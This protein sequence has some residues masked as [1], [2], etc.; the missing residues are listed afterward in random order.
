MDD[1]LLTATTSFST[2]NSDN[3]IVIIAI[4]LVICAVIAGITMFLLNYRSPVGFQYPTNSSCLC[5]I[6]I[7]IGSGDS[8]VRFTTINPPD[9]TFYA[10]DGAKLKLEPRFIDQLANLKIHTEQIVGMHAEQ[11]G[12]RHATELLQSQLD[13]FAAN[14]DELLHAV[15]NQHK[16]VISQP[17][18]NI[19]SNEIF[20]KNRC[21]LESTNS[22]L[23]HLGNRPASAT[24]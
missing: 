11:S 14:L 16:G 10:S 1:F 12:S 17:E 4:M 8:L 3:A 9:G 18:L 24:A 2:H 22:M 6:E 5:M 19:I 15:I 21:I 23:E 20:E 13:A 7:I